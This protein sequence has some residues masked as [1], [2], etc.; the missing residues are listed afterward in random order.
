MTEPTEPSPA[1][2]PDDL[3]PPVEPP[4][5]GFIVQL[6][7]VPL[8]IVVA[9]VTVYLMFNWLAHMGSGD[10]RKYLQEMRAG[11]ANSFQAAHDFATVLTRNG[12]L[13][14][15]AALA[16]EVAALLEREIASDRRDDESLKLRFYLCKAL[17]EFQVPDGLPVLLK[18]AQDRQGEEQSTENDFSVARVRGAAI[19]SIA[20]LIDNVRQAE[21]ETQVQ[22]DP[23]EADAA[24]A[25]LAPNLVPVLKK[26]AGDDDTAIR[27]A[28]AFALGVIGGDAARDALVRLLGDADP[29]IRYNAALGLARHGDARCQAVLVEMLDP[30][31]V[32]AG[33][34]NEPEAAQEYKRTQI[35]L[36]ALRAAGQLVAANPGADLPELRATVDRLAATDLNTQ[37]RVELEQLRGAWAPPQAAAAAR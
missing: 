15:D 11:G 3:L 1:V 20:V 10:P 36:N 34:L 16:G 18:A 30:D 13:K 26:G 23:S 7:V 4:S 12:E 35:V 33:V 17:G 29:N 9:I 28:S 31:Q 25:E 22:S 27:Q 37:V 19:E 5:A 24:F 2:S 32:P 6:F 14:Q 21:R 8:L